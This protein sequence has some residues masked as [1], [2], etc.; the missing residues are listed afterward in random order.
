[1]PQ[2]QFVTVVAIVLKIAAAPVAL[3]QD[4][5]AGSQIRYI[6]ELEQRNV[7]YGAGCNGIGVSLPP[8][9]SMPADIS[10]RWA[11]GHSACIPGMRLVLVCSGEVAGEDRVIGCLLRVADGSAAG[12]LGCDQLTLIA[13]DAR[14]KPDPGLSQALSEGS[15]GGSVPCSQPSAY[16]AGL[17]VAAA[18]L[19]PAAESRGDL[20]V[21][22][23]VDE[24]EVPAFL[25]PS[26][27]LDLLAAP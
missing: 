20:A 15:A 7:D 9:V 11:A 4:E 16:T 27:Q 19:V 23:D 13:P 5:P 1:V 6:K 8:T 14:F 26:G 2:R 25:I 21:L 18:F 12:S 24:S 17:T 3:A 22:I 10:T